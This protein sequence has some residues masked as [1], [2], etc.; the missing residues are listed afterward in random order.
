[1]MMPD[2]LRPILARL[3]EALQSGH[4]VFIAGT[5][6]FP[7]ASHPLP[8]LPPAYRDAGGTW[9]GG[10]YGNLWQLQA[11]EFLHVHAARGGL[12]D[13][14]IPGKA[15][16]QEFEELELAVAEGWR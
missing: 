3:G 10:A 11:G 8:V 16:V 13:V 7:D 14:P 2:P 5:L 6:S 4:R 1:M 9:H 15:R 12:I